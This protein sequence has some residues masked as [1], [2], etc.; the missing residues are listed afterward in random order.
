MSQFVEFTKLV[1]RSVAHWASELKRDVTALWIG[2]RDA[3]TPWP[4]KLLAGL[5]VA[6]ALS[7]IDLIPDFIPVI[8]YLDD[9][10]IVPFGL[11]LTI[12]LM[13]D[14]LMAEFRR[15]A[16]DLGPRPRSMAGLLFVGAVWLLAMIIF[17]RWF[18]QRF[19]V[20]TAHSFG[21]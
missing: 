8:G 11:W 20:M 19:A 2:S 16:V 14:E 1:L 12:R 15:R 17:F 18:E 13:P 5:V 4:S 3:R 10:I 9:L 21:A 6:Y 7:P